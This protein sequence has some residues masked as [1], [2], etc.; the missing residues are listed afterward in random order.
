MDHRPLL[1]G[2]G[3]CGLALYGAWS[4]VGAKAWTATAAAA[5]A[6]ETGFIAYP[7]CDSRLHPKQFLLVDRSDNIIAPVF[8]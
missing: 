2:W 6:R 8:G 1:W 3:W 4:H 5:S 7:L